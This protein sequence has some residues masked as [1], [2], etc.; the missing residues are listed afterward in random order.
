MAEPQI[1]EQAQGLHN[2]GNLD[3]AL[4]LYDNLL[5]QNHDNAGLLAT[6]GTLFLQSLQPG[7]A[8]VL[9]HKSIEATK[10]EVLSDVYCNLALAYKYS[11]QHDKAKVWF[12]KSI[13]KNPSPEALATYASLFIEAGDPAQGELYAKRALNLDPQ[14]P[15]AHWNYSLMLLESGQWDK[16]WDEYEWGFQA[17]MRIDRVLGG[18]PRW[19]G[20]SPGTVAI[21][22]E[23]GI[24]DEIMFA[25]MLPDVLKTNNV[26]LDTHSRLRNLFHKSFGVTCY[27]TREE[28]T[29]Q[30]QMEEKFDWQI[31]IG[32]LG[33]FYRRSKESYPGT[34]YL[35]ADPLPKGNKFRVGISWTGGLKAGRVRKRTIPLSWWKSILNNDCEFVS[36]QYTDCEDEIAMVE[37]EGYAIKQFP[38]A[39]AKDY[40][41]AAQLVKSC[42][43]V[44]SCCTSVIHLAGAL[45]VPCW[46]MTPKNPAWRYLNS[47]RMPWYR[48]VRLYR[49]QDDSPDGW[50]PVVQKIGY[51]LSELLNQQRKAA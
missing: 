9:L 17:K 43:L 40:Y 12:D 21:Y 30:W 50:I 25:S 24:G 35:K 5:T 28:N 38:E 33:Q 49:Q 37:G 32:S 20:V 22:G 51:D 44:I 8:M 3:G 14:L 41:Q 48:S 1:W 2:A 23:Q 19:D 16:A 26:I 45:G 27:G 42:D 29:P 10:G 31:S 15:L 11:G 46:V 7:I 18:K 36:L 6:V 39:K 34:P 47:G 4:K 13:K